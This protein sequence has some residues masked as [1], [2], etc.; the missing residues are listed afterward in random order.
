MERFSEIEIRLC[1]ST[2]RAAT[3]TGERD[4]ETEVICWDVERE[5]GKE[6]QICKTVSDL[7]SGRRERSGSL[8]DLLW[9]EQLLT[10]A[11]ATLMAEAEA[12]PEE[13]ERSGRERAVIG[14]WER[15]ISCEWETP[16]S[17]A[18]NSKWVDHG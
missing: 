12:E 11:K 1:T 14:F 10:T 13:W 2:T 3:V 9:T 7:I 8:T 4:E 15:E 5:S 6:K 18:R 16:N 17:K